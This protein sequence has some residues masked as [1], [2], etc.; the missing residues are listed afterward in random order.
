MVERIG[1]ARR[2][3]ITEVGLKLGVLLVELRTSLLGP[4]CSLATEPATR[5]STRNPSAVEAAF[6]Q[7]D[8]ALK[9]VCQLLGLRAA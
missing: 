4:L 6:R 1:K 7:L 9:R 5:R 3:R 8:G 2:Y